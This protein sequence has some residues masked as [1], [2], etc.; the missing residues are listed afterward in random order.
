M[1]G[2]SANP[3]L[4]R[5]ADRVQEDRRRSRYISGALTVAL[6]IMVAWSVDV[7]VIQDTDWERI[8]SV[9]NVWEATSHFI[10]LDLEPDK[11][12]RGDWGGYEVRVG[13]PCIPC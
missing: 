1:T 9:A 2:L 6:T 10:G 12:Y 8:G 13:Q 5:V 4:S 3:A 7:T 11:A